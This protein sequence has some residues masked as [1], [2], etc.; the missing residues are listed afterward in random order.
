MAHAR[1]RPDQV[2]VWGAVDVAAPD[3]FVFRVLRHPN[4]AVDGKPR[5]VEELLGCF[6][7]AGF[8]D[9]A[10]HVTSDSWR[11]TMSAVRRYRQERGW[12]TGLLRRVA[13]VPTCSQ[14]YHSVVNHSQD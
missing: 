1:P 6:Y 2:W 7:F 12:P 8:Q 10:L 11:A 14:Q 3:N 9:P 5:G 13:G 4:D